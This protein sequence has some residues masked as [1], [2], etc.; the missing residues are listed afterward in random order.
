MHFLQIWILHE[1]SGLTPGYEQ[2]TVPDAEKS[3]R[4]R[5]LASRTGNNGAVLVHQNV[6]LYAA[7]LENGQHVEHTL[8]AGR[9]AWVQMARG[10]A[11]VNGALLREGDGARIAQETMI[12]MAAHEQA[13]LLLFDLP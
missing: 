10:S 6:A 1:A 8:P 4:L 9:Q 5:L 11:K 2:I 7:L 13:E 12:E 3:G